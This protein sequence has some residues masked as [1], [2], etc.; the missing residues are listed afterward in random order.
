[1]IIT[2]GRGVAG[3]IA[4]TTG[5]DPDKGISE[6]GSSVGGGAGAEA[7]ANGVAPV[8]PLNLAGGL[9]A[10]TASVG[11]E[12]GREAGSGEEGLEGLNVLLLVIVGVGAGVGG[13]AS[14]APGV[15]VG[16]VGDEPTDRSRLAS[17]LVDAGKEISS[18]LDVG[19]PSQPTGVTSIEVHGNVGQVELLEGVDSQLLVGGR[20]SAALGNAHVGDHVGKRIGLDD[21]D[22]ADVRV[23]NEILAD[24]V[25]VGLVVGSTAVGNG[26]FAVGSGSSAVTVGKVVDNE[27][28]GLGGVGT[29][30]V[31]SANVGQGVGE[32]SVDSDVPVEPLEAGNLGNSRSLG[33]QRRRKAGD[34]KVVNL[35]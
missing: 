20:S 10:G 12:V 9:L 16:N 24:A 34:G 35:G 1:M 8:A 23:S 25:D 29:G 3:T 22:G 18:G 28:S 17:V 14:Q 15:V 13:G 19:G 26:P 5:L 2:S 33:G 11:D 7:G 21:E 27:V 31:G 30:L 6:L 32:E 4:F